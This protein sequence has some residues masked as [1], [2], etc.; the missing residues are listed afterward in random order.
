MG[1]YL[2]E[3][4]ISFEGLKLLLIPIKQ[5][6]LNQTFFLGFQFRFF[7]GQGVQGL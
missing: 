5:I 1:C 7:F 2:S 3:T 6:D 4:I